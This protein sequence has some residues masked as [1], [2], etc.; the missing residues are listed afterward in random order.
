MPRHAVSARQSTNVCGLAMEELHAIV[1]RYPEREM[2][3]RRLCQRDAEFRS[4]CGDY[5]E[6]VA[7][8]GRLRKA[9]MSDADG[10]VA[11]YTA[12]LAELETE[13]LGR[14]ARSQPRV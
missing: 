11:H 14:L 2:D 4:I 8:V 7:A 5:Q 9:G 13:I 3:F 6:A 1:R 12:F 10:R